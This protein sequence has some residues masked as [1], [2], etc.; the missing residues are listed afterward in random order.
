MPHRFHVELIKAQAVEDI[1]GRFSEASMVEIIESLDGSVG[2][3][4]APLEALQRT[5]AALAED[6][7]AER[8]LE[9]VLLQP[10]IPAGCVALVES[11]KEAGTPPWLT[12]DV[13]EDRVWLWYCHQLLHRAM[14]ERFPAPTVTKAHLAVRM[15]DVAG[16]PPGPRTSPHDRTEF[17]ATLLR[18]APEG[19]LT[20]PMGDEEGWAFNSVW[21]VHVDG[22]KKLE[23]DE[24]PEAIRPEDI[25]RLF[26][27]HMHVWVPGTT[28]P[29]DA[30]PA[31]WIAT[32]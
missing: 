28:L 8:L 16:R 9:G 32:A 5:F 22:R 14:P 20:S 7:L 17:V 24:L 3:E 1:A 18:Q 10:P 25:S 11:M 29:A 13:L 23:A 26:T 30:S 15:T 12:L 21:W 31:S 19:L 4:E 27:V 2:E 6:K